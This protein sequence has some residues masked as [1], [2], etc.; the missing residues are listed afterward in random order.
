MEVQR[1]ILGMFETNCFIVS[2]RILGKCILIDPAD[3]AETIRKWL[4]QQQLVPE[5]VLLTHGHYDH[6]LAVPKLQ[7]LWKELPVYCHLLDCPKEKEEH[8]MGMVFPT[9]NALSNLKGITE[10]QKLE[11]AGFEIT[12]YHTPGHT[13]G[14]VLFLVEDGLFTGDTLFRLSIGR[15]D[16]AGGDEAQMH[17]SLRRISEIEGDYNVYPGHEELTTLSAEKRN[18]PYLKKFINK[19]R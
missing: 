3:D 5:A 13:K 15:T 11:L 7:E 16:F 6:L 17:L 18:N 14:S 9:V 12:V 10:G 4:V 1:L 8:D 19:W 2:G